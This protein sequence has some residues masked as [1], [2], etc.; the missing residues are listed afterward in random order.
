MKLETQER[1][2]LLDLLSAAEGGYEAARTLR[3]ARAFIGFNADEM[4]KLRANEQI[5]PKEIR[6]DDLA[7]EY[8]RLLFERL[9]TDGKLR[10]EL[11]PLFEKFVF[12][13]FS[14]R[15]EK[16][17]EAEAERLK[18]ERQGKYTV[19]LVG[20]SPRSCGMAPFNDESI[21]LWGEN[22]SH[23]FRFFSRATRWFQIH[24]SYRQRLAKRGIRGHYD[25]LKR[26]EW[27]IPIYMQRK[28]QD[29]PYS[30][31]YPLTEICDRFLSR[32]DKGGKRVKYFNSSFDYMIAVAL[33]EDF[34]R[35]EIYGFDMAGDNEYSLQKPSAEFW[36]GVASQHAE[37]YLP[38]NCMLLKSELYGGEEQGEGWQ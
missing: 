4:E 11:V 31:A 3:R 29:I 12:V 9:D 15:L 27:N 32:I 5:E 7:N 33:L 36:L 13:D 18:E 19:A 26:N 10:A 22:E 1:M 28:S 38:D 20:L 6:L 30:R 24:K 2:Y 37:I 35:I 21:E 16:M 8:I 34:E 17:D 25:W 14:D 23:A